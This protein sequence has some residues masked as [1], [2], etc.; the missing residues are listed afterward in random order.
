MLNKLCTK[1]MNFIF[2]H[3]ILAHVYSVDVACSYV[4]SIFLF[5]KFSNWKKTRIFK[6]ETKN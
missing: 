2:Q 3:E 5:S 6:Y 4:K 1:K